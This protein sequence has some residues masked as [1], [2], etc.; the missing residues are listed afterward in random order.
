MWFVVQEHDASTLHY[1]FRLEVDG[2]LK[3]WE[4]GG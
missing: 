3:S 2:V 1:H 4:R